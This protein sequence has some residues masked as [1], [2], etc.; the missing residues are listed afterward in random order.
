MLDPKPSHTKKDDFYI[1]MIKYGKEKLYEGVEISDVKLHLEAK[2]FT[3]EGNKNL[4]LRE[5]YAQIFGSQEEQSHG[6]PFTG[7][8]FLNVNSY[9]SLLDHEELEFAHKSS[10]EDGVSLLS[11]SL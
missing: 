6:Y 11:L 4:L 3:F 9:F 7:K 5:A 2:G 8:H 10:A 1:E